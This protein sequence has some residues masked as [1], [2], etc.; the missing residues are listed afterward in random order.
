MLPLERRAGSF[1]DVGNGFADR[2]GNREHAVSLSQTAPIAFSKEAY[3]RLAERQVSGG[4][5]IDLP[6]RLVAKRVQLAE[7]GEIVDASVRPRV[8]H[9]NKA[10]FQQHTETV[11]HLCSSPSRPSRLVASAGQAA[12]MEKQRGPITVPVECAREKAPITGARR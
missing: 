2:P 12:P 11:S 4:R 3:R 6:L 1:S 9:Q 7:R 10:R 5:R 8:G